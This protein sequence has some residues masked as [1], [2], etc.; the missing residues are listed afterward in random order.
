M[1]P[2]LR[3]VSTTV[4]FLGVLVL[5]V[6]ALVSPSD[7][8]V[9]GRNC[10]DI[11][12]G[13]GWQKKVNVPGSPATVTVTA[14]VDQ[15]I[16]KYCVKAGS[17][18]GAAVLVDVQPPAA[19]VVVDHPTQATVSQYAVHLIPVPTITEPPGSSGPSLPPASG[20][21]AP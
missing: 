4:V 1:K 20:S 19:V 17:G 21:A 5:G 6:M 10:K 8:V 15:V 11:T 12:V 7:A 13:P 2:A 16:D 9:T 3:A 14:P 18:A